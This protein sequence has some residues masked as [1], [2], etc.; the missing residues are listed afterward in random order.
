MFSYFSYFVGFLDILIDF[1]GP[2]SGGGGRQWHFR[3]LNCTNGVS[4]FQGSVGGPG[5]GKPQGCEMYC[6][7]AVLCMLQLACLTH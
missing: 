7:R 6:T 2:F 4:G 3:T 1:W 5:D